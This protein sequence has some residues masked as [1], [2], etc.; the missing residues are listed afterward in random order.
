M[1]AACGFA[2]EM[3]KGL[4]SPLAPLPKGEGTYIIPSPLAPL[5]KGEG[6]Y[7]I[8]SPLAPLPMGDGM[9]KMD[10][11]VRGNYRHWR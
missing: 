8:P 5:P 9:F 4:P 11:Y 7:I 6:T 3:E 10:F 2:I 1:K